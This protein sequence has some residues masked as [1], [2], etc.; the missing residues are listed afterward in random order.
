MIDLS[1][2]GFLGIL[3]I[4]LIIL[5]Y[6]KNTSNPSTTILSSSNIT[7]T[8]TTPTTTTPTTTTTTPTTTTTTTPTTT[9]PTTTTPT[10]TI[11]TT[12]TP[13]TTTP[14]T[15][16]PT[17]TT[18]TTTTPTTTTTIPI[19]PL[20][21]L[22]TPINTIELYSNTYYNGARQT[23]VINNRENLAAGYN[24]VNL[25][26]IKVQSLRFRMNSFN[27][28]IYLLTKSQIL[29]PTSLNNLTSNRQPNVGTIILSDSPVFNFDNLYY[30]AFGII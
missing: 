22:I 15:T 24:Y 26:M 17:T 13:T 2:L 14:T 11:P 7:T 16:T 1:H 20:S 5:L 29:N 18:P 3:C 9:I 27:I 30:L 21:S 8:T 6:G 28:K 19:S 12:T 10:T 23:I 4:I 25:E